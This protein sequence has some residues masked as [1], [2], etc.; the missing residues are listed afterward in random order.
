MT[1]TDEE[2][3]AFLDNQLEE[4]QMKSIRESL[5]ED[6]LLSERFENLVFV[7]SLVQS[8]YATID[9]KP[10]PQGIV[11]ILSEKID[12]ET[13]NHSS[14]GLQNI[15]AIVS[16]RSFYA[17]MGLLLAFGFWGLNI[18]SN[19]NQRQIVSPVL[20]SGLVDPDSPLHATLEEVPSAVSTTIDQLGDQVLTPVLTFISDKGQYCREIILHTSAASSR[21]VA[22]RQNNQQW[23]VE[24]SSLQKNQVLEN[25]Y[26]TASS[27]SPNAF[28]QYVNQMIEDEPFSP[29]YELELIKN[30]WQ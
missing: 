12:L 16:N 20:I 10:L 6:H 7:D 13:A 21:S 11:N 30:S 9:S 29:E 18:G 25:N 5:I 27:I 22:C 8:S 26:S 2:L 19:V 14:G 4:H 3:N 28:E 15:F 23:N 17:T 24:L 1:Y